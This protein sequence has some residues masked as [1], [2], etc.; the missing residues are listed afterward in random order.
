MRKLNG[1]IL[2]FLFIDLFSLRG[3]AQAFNSVDSTHNLTYF[4]YR[5]MP[6]NAYRVLFIGDSLTYHGQTPNLWNYDSGMAASAPERDFVHLVAKHIQEKLP[7]KPVETL[8]DN[9][10]NGKIGSML[11]YIAKHPELKPSL[12]ILQGG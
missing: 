9:G 1:A 7:A 11:A 10:G 2:G 8:I 3:A 4:N 12:V 6:P 5:P